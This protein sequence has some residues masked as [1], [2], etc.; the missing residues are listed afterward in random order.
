MEN[1]NWPG[2]VLPYLRL[3]S[4]PQPDCHCADRIVA[5]LNYDTVRGNLVDGHLGDVT[6]YY[7]I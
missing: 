4:H 5:S 6:F 3:H 7:K 1:G 2:R